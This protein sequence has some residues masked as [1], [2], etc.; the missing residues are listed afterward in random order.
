[1]KLN[2]N[3]IKDLLPLYADQICS[4]ESRGLVEEHLTDCTDCSAL[5]RQMRNEEMENSLETEAVDVLHRQA[6]FLRGSPL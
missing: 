2:C 1:M 5:L 3:V 6:K 4:E